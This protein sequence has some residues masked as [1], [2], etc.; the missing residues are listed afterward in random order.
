M[1]APAPQ[2]Q[3]AAL[4]SHGQGDDGAG[5]RVVG[6]G[7]QAAAGGLRQGLGD[8]AQPLVDGALHLGVVP[9]DLRE[10]QKPAA[11][12]LDGLSAGGEQ[13]SKVLQEASRAVDKGLDNL[14][15]RGLQTDD[16]EVGLGG[17]VVEDSAPGDSGE[18]G[19]VIDRHR[20]VAA[21]PGQGER[22]GADGG[23]GALR[24]GGAQVGSGHATILHSVQTCTQC[25]FAR[26]SSRRSSRRHAQRDP[27]RSA[28][29]HDVLGG[30]QI[31]Y[32][33]SPQF[34]RAERNRVIPRFSQRL[35]RTLDSFVSDLDTVAS[36]STWAALRHS[37]RQ[38]PR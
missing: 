8:D 18:S 23:T 12:G 17:E 28:T 14:G 27:T 20:G 33:G 7:S 25:K 3:G 34:G 11:L 1:G 24:L 29:G 2:V 32:K 16:E 22:G 10:G 5:A 19:D 21:L 30:V 37:R 36:C 35:C 6:L 38:R 9:H 13:D 15:R 4:N 31:G 26:G